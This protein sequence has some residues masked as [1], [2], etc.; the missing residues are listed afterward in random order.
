MSR[1]WFKCWSHNWLRGTRRLDPYARGCYW[2]LICLIHENGGPIDD[3]A[4]FIASELHITQ[5]KWKAVRAKLIDAGKITVL[6]GKLSNKRAEIELNDG[7]NEHGKI[8]EA[9]VK[10]EEKRRGQGEKPHKNRVTG[11]DTVPETR[12]EIK[13]GS[14]HPYSR[15][16]KKEDSG[17]LPPTQSPQPASVDI[18]DRPPLR[19]GAGKI[20]T[21]F[22][23]WA[24]EGPL[25][26]A[27][28]ASLDPISP[29]LHQL[30]DLISWIEGGADFDHDILPAIEAKAAGLKPRMVKSW[31]F[32]GQAVV[33]AKARRTATLP[34]PTD[35][36][37]SNDRAPRGI[38]TLEEIQAGAER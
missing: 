32:F 26:T 38:F 3:D 2:D 5:R 13:H 23:K 15:G 17:V 37:D 33:N 28:G 31:G 16:Q 25:W 22:L 4:F 14:N 27:G 30:S 11:T 10:R 20:S 29:N 21:R 35:A 36:W 7:Q 12:G 6:D 1:P 8:S 9:A 19:D 18:E 24:I 34:E